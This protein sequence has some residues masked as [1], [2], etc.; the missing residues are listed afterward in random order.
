MLA[1]SMSFLP[2]AATMWSALAEIKPAAALIG[3]AIALL[4][5]GEAT[6]QSYPS[7]PIRIISPFGA[8]GALDAPI[9]PVAQKLAAR[10]GQGVVIEN[11]PG[12]G[13]TIA[14]KAAASASPDG[15]TLLLLRT[16]NIINTVLFENLGFDFV[17][18]LAPVASISRETLVMVVHP[19]VPARTVPEFIAY[20]K[21]NPGKLKMASAGVGT[22]AHVAGE[23]FKL[24]AGVDLV[25]VPY[26]DGALSVEDMLAGR[27][28]VMFAPASASI[29]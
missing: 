2:R 10:F 11:R 22:P 4:A 15:Y 3:L 9:R 26:R 17:R 18:D 16:R 20:A 7:K 12:G 13:F 24:L 6:A 27:A 19:S 23:L 5:A 29:G 25:H 28:Q 1:Q 14:G 8:G 21:A